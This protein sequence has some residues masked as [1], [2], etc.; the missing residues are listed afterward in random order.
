MSDSGYVSLADVGQELSVS[1]W[2]VRRWAQEGLIKCIRL[3]SGTL[4][5]PREELERVKAAELGS[6]KEPIAV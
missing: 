3:P 4:R 1:Y 2:T 5:V 6:E